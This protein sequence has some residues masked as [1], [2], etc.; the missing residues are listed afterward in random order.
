MK[1]SV[2]I[3]I[4]FTKKGVSSNRIMGDVEFNLRQL[5]LRNYFSNT[6]ARTTGFET[7]IHELKTEGRAKSA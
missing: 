3:V 5:L 6:A 1:V 2:N 7:R 4:D